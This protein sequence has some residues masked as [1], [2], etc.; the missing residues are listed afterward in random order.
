MKEEVKLPRGTKSTSGRERVKKKEGWGVTGTMY[1]VQYKVYYPVLCN[2][3][4]CTT[5]IQICS[6]NKQINKL[7]KIFVLLVTSTVFFFFFFIVSKTHLESGQMAQ[8]VRAFVS[9]VGCWCSFRSQH[10]QC[11]GLQLPV[12]PAPWDPMPFSSLCGHLDT[13]PYTCIHINK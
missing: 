3:A 12:S 10:P 4:P 7:E 6:K 8:H 2:T 1:N 13:P 11:G 5:T 9:L